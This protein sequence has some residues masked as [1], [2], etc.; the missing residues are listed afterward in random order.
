[1]RLASLLLVALPFVHFSTKHWPNPSRTAKAS[2]KAAWAALPSH[3]Q[4]L[5]P[6]N[7]AAP[8]T[9]QA[10]NLFERLCQL[11]SAPQQFARTGCW[12]Q[13][14]EVGGNDGIGGVGGP[15]KW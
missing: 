12:S 4:T 8:K 13:R 3:V 15:C 6:A 1:M 10:C 2:D 5:H 11:E 14:A 7:D 9:S